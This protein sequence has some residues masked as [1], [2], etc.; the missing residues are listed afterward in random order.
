[1]YNYHKGVVSG[2]A[3]RCCC[4]CFIIY[5]HFFFSSGGFKGCGHNH[6]GH[7]GSWHWS[8]CASTVQDSIC[9][10]VEPV[11]RSPTQERPGIGRL[12]RRATFTHSDRLRML[13]QQN[14]GPVGGP[15][16]TMR[17]KGESMSRLRD[18][19]PMRLRDPSPMRL[20]EPSP[21]RLRDPSPMRMRDPSPMRLRDPS[22]M[23]VR[24]ASPLNSGLVQRGQYAQSVGGTAPSLTLD[25]RA[26]K[27]VSF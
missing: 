19:S 14:Q 12:Q 15:Q 8:C 26:W 17:G 23:R 13:Q 22:P 4:Y 20:R 25:S 6:V 18:P 1:M 7:P 5:S 3:T 24:D 2:V 11:I 21:M 16:G 27:N 9:S 10:S